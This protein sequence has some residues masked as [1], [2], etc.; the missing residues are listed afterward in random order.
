[1]AET[2]SGNSLHMPVHS[3]NRDTRRMLW[4]T[5]GWVVGLFWLIQLVEVTLI[6]MAEG[7]KTALTLLEPRAVVLVAGMMLSLPIIGVAASAVGK[8]FARRLV[9]TVAMALVMCAVLMA[10]NYGVYFIA[11]STGRRAFDLIEF[12]YTGFGWSWFFL[13]LAGAVIAI[14]YSA[15]VRDRE[16]R[17][18]V[19]SEVAKDA[20]LAALRY[21]LN[22]HFLFNT[23][24]SISSLIE[25]RENEAA[26]TMVLSLS[27]FLRA[28]LE[29]DPVEDVPL[30]REIE[31]Q[32][33][34][35]SIEEVRF[36]L[37]L[38]TRYRISDDVRNVPVPAL[39]TQPIIENAIRHAVARSRGAVLL[40]IEAS[41]IKDRLRISITDDGKAA[42]PATGGTGV[43][44]ENVRARLESRFGKDQSL[45]A[46]PI[47]GG[48]SVTIELPIGAPQ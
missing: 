26:E 8:P 22:P 10:V 4:R 14:A 40:T 42:S 20:R 44:M 37:R 32:A 21:Q 36:P 2:V 41:R 39:I 17:L 27:D 6:G 30:E 38:S 35:L 7:K 12:I 3:D 11:F 33:L 48:F 43:G 34:Y 5:G 25:A 23:L 1:M 46:G 13:G 15:E 18:A 24:N 16:R 31:L 19:M 28:T 45:T 29:L 47:P 9:A